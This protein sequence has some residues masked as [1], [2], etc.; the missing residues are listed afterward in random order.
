MFFLCQTQ[1]LAIARVIYSLS[2][3]SYTRYRSCHIL[4]I[5]RVIWSLSLPSNARYRSRHTI[6]NYRM[7]IV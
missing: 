1:M 6:E 3:V 7:T 5:A 2:L 4:A